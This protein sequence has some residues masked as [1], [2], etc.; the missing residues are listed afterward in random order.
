VQAVR[1]EAAGVVDRELSRAVVAYLR[2]SGLAWP[3][4]TPEAVATELGAEATARLMPR[5]KQL[6][7]E[8]VYWPVDWQ[9][10]DLVSA[11]RAVEEDITAAHPELDQNA[12]RALGW[13]FSY[14]NK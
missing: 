5:L 7:R 1:A 2:G 12:V 9:D 8:A 11:T 13:Y 4:E 3:T 10:H 6:A 14:C